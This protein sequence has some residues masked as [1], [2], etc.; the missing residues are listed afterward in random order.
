MALYVDKQVLRYLGIEKIAIKEAE[1][2][3]S[4]I[5]I[6]FFQEAW[7][8]YCVTEL[9][10]NRGQ[11]TLLMS[12]R[13]EPLSAPVHITGVRGKRRHYTVV[14][15]HALP[16]ELQYRLTLLQNHFDTAD[17]RGERRLPAGVMHW[18]TLGLKQLYQT[19]LIDG[20]E[21]D[22]IIENLAEHGLLLSCRQERKMNIRD[23]MGLRLTFTDPSLT[24][25][26]QLSPVRFFRKEG[27]VF[28]AVRIKEPLDIHYRMRIAH[29]GERV[30]SSPHKCIVCHTQEPL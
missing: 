5:P 11:H 16:L 7:L 15:I 4:C 26:L 22:C 27:R 8:L 14:F 29:Y 9:S 21:Y 12:Y 24:C 30:T 19:V 17:K 6:F 3:H 20:Y 18:K 2:V 10:L 25:F 23:P 28:I 13:G 1:T